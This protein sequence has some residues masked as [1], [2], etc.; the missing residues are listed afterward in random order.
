MPSLLTRYRAEFDK[1]RTDLDAIRDSAAT[2]DR[3]L[4]TVE[5]TESARLL[6]RAG[7]LRPLIESEVDA[8]E[9]TDGVAGL[10]ARVNGALEVATQAQPQVRAATAVPPPEQYIAEWLRVSHRDNLTRSRDVEDFVSRWRT[11]AQQI[12]S[13]NAGIV[14]APIIGPAIS[15]I[16]GAR[17]VVPSFTQRPMPASGSTFTRPKIT[18]H[19]SVFTQ[20]AQGVELASADIQITSDTVTKFTEGGT[21]QLSQQN[22]DWTDPAILAIVVQDF[23]D[24]YARRTDYRAA[25]SLA[26]AAASTVAYTSTDPGTIILSLAT[27]S[28]TVYTA[29]CMPP[30][31][32]WLAV[33]AAASLSALVD[34]NKRPVFTEFGAGRV[35]VSTQNFGLGNLAGLNVVVSPDLAAGKK[36]VGAKRY[37]EWYED[38][39]GFLQIT[40][41]STL[42]TELATYGYIGMYFK[43][44]GF[45]TLS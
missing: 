9:I 32:L 14:P 31:T 13:D 27:A 30:D 44:E 38:R 2:G 6:A 21:L 4:T 43:S 25:T 7:E 33:D 1:I 3:D 5:Q 12:T 23:I 24:I 39:R 40:T 22:M 17:Y 42:I 26:A 41:P 34:S 10:F 16:D 45:V 19:A 36:I 35:D 20:S 37:A 8:R 28:K 11:V 18:S 29:C 15:F